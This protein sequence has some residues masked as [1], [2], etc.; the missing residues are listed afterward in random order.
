[1]VGKFPGSPGPEL[2]TSHQ[3][4]RNNAVGAG[5]QRLLVGGFTEGVGWAE[6]CYWNWVL[7]RTSTSGVLC[8]SLC[9]LAKADPGQVHGTRI[10]SSAH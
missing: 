4:S 5:K 9:G 1:M 3:V 2:V 7:K 10:G 6:G 8:T